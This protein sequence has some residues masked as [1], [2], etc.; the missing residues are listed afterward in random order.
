M[1][2]FAFLLGL[3]A[4][5]P[6]S[7]SI[8]DFARDIRPLP[9]DYCFPCHGT[10]KSQGD[11]YIEWLGN[12]P[13]VLEEVSARLEAQRYLDEHDT[14]PISEKKKPGIDERERLRLWS[15]WA[16]E[17]IDLALQIEITDRYLLRRL[18]KAE[19]K[20]TCRKQLGIPLELA[21]D[22][23]EEKYR[24]IVLDI[25]ALA[26]QRHTGGHCFNAMT[27]KRSSAIFTKMFSYG[28]VQ[29]ENRDHRDG[30]ANGQPP[31]AGSRGLATIPHL[32][33]FR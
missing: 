29:K 27:V 17:T 33:F 23:P 19:L 4:S 8:A 3:I 28:V 16:T 22:F 18:S 7:E 12:Q 31:R 20:N 6:D 26:P 10:A 24:D 5:A 21:D 13:P 25:V 30:T 14:S 9:G 1:P 11:L 2:W 32:E 15:R